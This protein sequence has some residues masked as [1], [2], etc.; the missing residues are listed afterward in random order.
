MLIKHPERAKQII[1]FEGLERHRKIMP[2][3]IDGFIDYNGSS[4]VYIEAKLDRTPVQYGQRMAFENVVKSHDISGHKS[5]AVIIRHNTRPEEIIVAKDQIVDEF[6][7]KYESV[8]EWR[9]PKE[10][11]YNLL[12]FLKW[13]ELECGRKGIVL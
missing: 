12:D 3:D 1:S 5:C 10:H 11:N 8:Y 2:T 13:W 9:M 6:Y 4:F 7:F